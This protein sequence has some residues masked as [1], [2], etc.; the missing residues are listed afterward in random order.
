MQSPGTTNIPVGWKLVDTKRLAFLGCIPRP[1]QSTK[2]TPHWQTGEQAD[3]SLPEAVGSRGLR[4]ALPCFFL[5]DIWL[6]LFP[7]PFFK[8]MIHSKPVTQGAVGRLDHGLLMFL[9][10]EEKKL[11][12]GSAGGSH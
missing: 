2:H 11:R 6:V 8:N 4:K 12:G 9:Y 7:H 3:P 10:E 1:R 5:T